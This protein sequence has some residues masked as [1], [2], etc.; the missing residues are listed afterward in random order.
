[1]YGA[2]RKSGALFLSFSRKK[3]FLKTEKY[4]EWTEDLAL[5]LVTL[6][7]DLKFALPVTRIHVMT[8][9]NL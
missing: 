4:R 5:I 8:L 3:R 7:F 1:V 2:N 9:R 6:T